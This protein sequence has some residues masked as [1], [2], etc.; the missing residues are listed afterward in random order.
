MR[1]VTVVGKSVELNYLWL[2]TWLGEN[3]AFKNALDKRLRDQV[4][5][6]PLTEETLNE[7][8]NKILAF[9]VEMYPLEGLFD[10]LDGLK[11]VKV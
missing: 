9:I 1:V 6:K 10:Y 11:F 4:V 7:L 5:G 2:P 3:I 8:H